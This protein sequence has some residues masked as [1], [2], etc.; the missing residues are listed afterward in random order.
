MR[1]G[2][3][4]DLAETGA[5]EVVCTDLAAEARDALLGPHAARTL[6]TVCA[7]GRG[8]ER[9]ASLERISGLEERNQDLYSK[10]IEKAAV[11]RTC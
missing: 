5:E 3:A 4:H 8:L 11:L 1:P 7:S 6:R 10:V 9:E 2:A